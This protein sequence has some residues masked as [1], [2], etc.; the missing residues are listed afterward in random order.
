LNG[1]A[2]LHPATGYEPT[3]GLTHKGPLNLPNTVHQAVQMDEM[4]AIIFDGK[5][6]VVPVDGEEALK[7]L[8]VIEGIYKS[9]QTG[10]TVNL[11][12]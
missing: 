10:K 2:E 12:L 6:P 9:A 5:K 3:T 7:D 8:K 4:A 11:Q 1:F